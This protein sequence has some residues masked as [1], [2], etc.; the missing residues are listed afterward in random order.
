MLSLVTPL[1]LFGLTLLPVIRW[2]HRGG[3]HRRAVPVSH[4][5]LWRGSAA[6]QPAAGERR[7]PDPAW[8]RRAA[9]TALLFV[10]LAEPQLP[11]PRPAITVWVD[12]SLSM[13]TREA[14]G[15]RLVEG[16]AQVRALL[17]EVGHADVDLR[18]LGDPWHSLGAPTDAAVATLA[19]GAGRTEPDAPPAALLRRDSLH[20]LVTDGADTSLFEWPDGRHPDR[21]IRVARV[22]RNVGLQRLAARRHPN[23]PDKFDLLLKVANGG[24]AAETRVAVFATD[25]GEVARS[26]QHLDAGT[27]ALVSA[28][29][30]ASASVRATLQ[31]GD[32]LAEDDQI[33]L[34]LAPLRRRRVAADSNC[35]ASIVAAVATHPALALAPQG[36]TDVEAVL[37]CGTRG[38]SS[39]LAT[40]R[41]LADRTPAG[42]PG[43][44][45]W[46]ST[47]AESH[48]IGL[49]PERLQLAARVQARPADTVLLAVGDEPV[50][51]DRA[52][53]SRLIETSLDFGSMAIR[54]G[55]EV[56]LLVNLMFER[57]FGSALLD[58]VAITDRG[59]A[60]VR[61]APSQGVD[62]GAV[63]QAPSDSRILHDGVRP[64]LVVA[65]LALLWE[66]GA[67][68]RQWVRL[69][70]DAEA[71]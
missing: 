51:V 42:P 21:V 31:P 17:A 15:T 10:A 70:A 24:T 38:T 62:A 33:V 26:T 37:D 39:N 30:P 59:A 14:Q 34:D 47:V 20:W 29:I 16:M 35:P 36:A 40:I 49:T 28:V 4:L 55:P 6:S 27:S 23:D 56:P 11:T 65:L 71:E 69:R 57:L 5:G 64:L 67:L 25:A 58:A 32:A 48:R 54:S 3:R 22:T 18:T 1:W 63:A 50:I 19:A 53:A 41:V 7:P 46:S 12:D 13:L 44:V 61:V 52:G 9:L 45:R 8:R 66:L 60:A 43:S 68:G 2:L